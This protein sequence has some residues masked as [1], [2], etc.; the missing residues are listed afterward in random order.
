MIG[1][2]VAWITAD[3][4]QHILHQ[5]CRRHGPGR[6]ERDVGDLGLEHR[7]TAVRLA[8]LYP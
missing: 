3:L 1:S 7:R 2:Q 5:D 8:D 6:V 4:G